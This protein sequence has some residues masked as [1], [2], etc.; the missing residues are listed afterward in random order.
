M[1]M[2]SAAVAEDW[3]LVFNGDDP[4][5]LEMLLV[6]KD[7]LATVDQSTGA[8][9]AQVFALENNLQVL[10]V[11][12]YRCDTRQLKVESAKEFVST[13]A[14]SPIRIQFPEGWTPIPSGAQESAFAFVCS[15]NEREENQMMS[16]HKGM[17]LEMMVGHLKSAKAQVSRAYLENK[18]KDAEKAKVDY[19]MDGLDVLLDNKTEAPPPASG[20]RRRP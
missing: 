9:R 4:Y 15:P 19:V 7:S 11:H 18:Q 8:Q 10:M 20:Q 17:G 5:T 2:S 6:D 16:V 13:G 1:A 14:P 3:W 12:Q